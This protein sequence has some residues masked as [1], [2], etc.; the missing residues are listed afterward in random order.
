MVTKTVDRDNLSRSS[1]DNYIEGLHIWVAY[2]RC[3]IHRFALDFLGLKLKPFQIL[4]LYL[5]H[6]NNFVMVIAARGLG[7]SFLIAIY[8]CC[9][10]ILYPRQTYYYWSW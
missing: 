6:V 5:M 2:W 3:N 1:R 7:K 10:A 4:L 9:V 8:C